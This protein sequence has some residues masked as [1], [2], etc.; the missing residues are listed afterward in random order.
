MA[1]RAVTAFLSPR[2]PEN[3]AAISFFYGKS[4]RKVGEAPYDPHKK[5]KIFSCQKGRVVRG[6]RPRFAAYSSILAYL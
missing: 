6:Y 5:E 4:W 3:K 2:I 1:V